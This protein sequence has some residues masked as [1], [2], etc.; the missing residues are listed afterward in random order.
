MCLT[1]FLQLSQTV[2][3]ISNVNISNNFTISVKYQI[4]SDL[5]FIHEENYMSRIN[6][7][8]STAINHIKSR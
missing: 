5:H 3:N 7:I 1:T 4:L 2:V 6:I 8:V